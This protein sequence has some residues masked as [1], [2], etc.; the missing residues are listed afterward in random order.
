MCAVTALGAHSSSLVIAIIDGI[1]A[2]AR[3][4]A[5]NAMKWTASVIYSLPT[6][7]PRRSSKTGQRAGVITSDSEPV[8]V[9]SFEDLLVGAGSNIPV[10]Q[11]T[12]SYGQ[13]VMHVE[14]QRVLA[15]LS[16]EA[17]RYIDE[18]PRVMAMADQSQ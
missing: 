6:N 17:R 2:G 11:R 10:I 3:Q 18:L 16:E 4:N 12:C 7:S 5:I 9:A 8:D 15:Q 14:R 13:P 1:A